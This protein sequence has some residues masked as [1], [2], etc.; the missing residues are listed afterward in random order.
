MDR[1]MTKMV[2]NMGYVDGRDRLRVN[3][4]AQREADKQRWL[5]DNACHGCKKAF[6]NTIN[7]NEC[8]APAKMR[9]TGTYRAASV[10]SKPRFQF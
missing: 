10:N 4:L 6:V 3:R 8:A 1:I 9:R 5:R 7:C 2:A